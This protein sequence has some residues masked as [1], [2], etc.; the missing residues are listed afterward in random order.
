MENYN[1]Q[2]YY[3]DSAQSQDSRDRSQ[4]DQSDWSGLTL[5]PEGAR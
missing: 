2:E 1:F 3:P 4:G 5:T